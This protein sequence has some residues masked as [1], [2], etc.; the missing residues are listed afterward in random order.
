MSYTR[1][2]GSGGKTKNSTNR[3]WGSIFKAMDRMVQSLERGGGGSESNMMMLMLS[4]QMQQIAQQL[5]LHQQMF[6]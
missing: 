6:H 4:M 2:E 1:G 5:L 3:K